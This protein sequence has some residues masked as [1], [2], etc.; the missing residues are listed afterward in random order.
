MGYG[1]GPTQAI[2]TTMGYGVGP[3]QA[4]DT[5]EKQSDLEAKNSLKVLILGSKPPF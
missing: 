5:K 4:I 1:V 3:T 2:D